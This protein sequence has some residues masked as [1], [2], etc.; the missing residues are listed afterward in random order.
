MLPCSGI[1]SLS[2]LS[3]CPSLLPCWNI[4]YQQRKLG[5][6]APRKLMDGSALPDH[7]DDYLMYD[8]CFPEVPGLL[9]SLAARLP[10]IDVLVLPPSTRWPH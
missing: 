8:G 7:L 6:P 4:L 1:E 3:G 2:H 5:V 10:P 9:E